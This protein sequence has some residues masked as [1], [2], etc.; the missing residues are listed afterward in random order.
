MF[1]SICCAHAVLSLDLHI[2]MTTL[3]FLGYL[4]TF[5][6]C[7]LEVTLFN[8]LCHLQISAFQITRRTTSTAAFKDL[9]TQSRRTYSL[10]RRLTASLTPVRWCITTSS[11]GWK[12]QKPTVNWTQMSTS[13]SCRCV[14]IG[15]NLLSEK[16]ISGPISW[17]WGV[18][19]DSAHT[20]QRH[21]IGHGIFLVRIC[22][23]F[24]RLYAAL[25]D[26]DGVEGVTAIRNA[27][28][29]LNEQIRAYESKGTLKEDGNYVLIFGTLFFN[30]EDFIWISAKTSHAKKKLHTMC[31]SKMCCNQRGSVS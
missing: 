5:K 1:M 13:T 8:L 23:L 18:W 30:K 29:S 4:P 25:D 14:Q 27:Q 20:P 21:D 11:W 19:A 26:A 15:G 10:E 9:S 2:M 16:N 31:Y 6:V 7:T 24:Q 12:R 22:E 3:H 28:P 17:H